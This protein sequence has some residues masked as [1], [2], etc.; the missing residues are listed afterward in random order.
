M[1][2]PDRRG[3]LR[4]A[5]IAGAAFLVLTASP[6]AAQDPQPEKW[7]GVHKLTRFD[8]ESTL[9]FGHE[10]E[11]AFYRGDH[12][13]LAS[14]YAED[15]RLIAQ[16]TAPVVGRK[17]IEEF[18][19][20]ACKRARALGMKRA[21]LHDE[22]DRSGDLGYMRSRTLLEIPTKQ[23]KP[24]KIT[25]RAVTTWKREADGVW[26]M[27]VDLSNTD[28]SLESGKTPYGVDLKG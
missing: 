15:A 25:A 28:I 8:V 9:R 3:F 2:T 10:F 18:W 26:R 13:A 5:A 19:K 24:L 6:A 21:I 20:S 7:T 4:R 27:T 1:R 22:L 14:V 16:G 11:E 12:K 17:A 23:G